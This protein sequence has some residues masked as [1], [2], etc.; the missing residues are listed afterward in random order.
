MSTDLLHVGWVVPFDDLNEEEYLSA[1]I[2]PAVVVAL[3]I[4][5]V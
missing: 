5:S 4:Q 3:L 1:G 2:G